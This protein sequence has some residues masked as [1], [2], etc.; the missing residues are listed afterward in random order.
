MTFAGRSW[1]YRQL[2][3]RAN[4]I[5]HRLTGLGVRPGG[6][7]AVCAERSLDLVAALLGVL[8]TGAA[9]VPLDPGYPADRLA[10]MLADSGAPVVLTQQDLAERLATGGAVILPLDLDAVWDGLPA[11]PPEA[12]GEPGTAAYM[13]YTSGSTGRPKGVPNSHRG[14]VNRLDWMQKRFRLT[15]ADVVLQKTPAGFDVSVWEFFWPLLT[16]ARL[17]LAEPG[18]HRDPAYLRDLINAERVTV[19][20]FVPSMLGAFLAEEGVETCTSPRVI[21]CSGEELPV[22]LA[23]R[24]LR[25]LPAELHNLYGPTEAAIDVSAW[26][27]TLPALAGRARVPIGSPIQNITLHVLD[28]HGEPVPV[29]CPAS[30]TSAAW[31]SRSATT[32]ARS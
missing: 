29:G 26:Q 14:I 32:P 16:G 7:V 18:G 12:R 27:C 25:T 19:L 4:R 24:C 3:E 2:D 6:L 21:V 20:H 22:D 30:C 1:T 11:T 23:E 5:A 17:V 10:F 28:R 15:D 8:K 9:Y 13:I 31:A